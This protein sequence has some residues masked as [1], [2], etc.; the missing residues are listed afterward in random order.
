[1]S[2]HHHLSTPRARESA[3]AILERNVE[4]ALNGA[5]GNTGEGSKDEMN[6]GVEQGKGKETMIGNGNGLEMTAGQ[7]ETAAKVERALEERARASVG[8]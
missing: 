3:R 2:P 7:W 6:G 5:S 1:M 8:L 4:S